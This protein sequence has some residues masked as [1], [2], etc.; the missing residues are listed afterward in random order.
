VKGARVERAQSVQGTTFYKACTDCP[1][2]D[3]CITSNGS[4][5]RFKYRQDTACV[6]SASYML[7]TTTMM[8][9]SDY[10]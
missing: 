2:S 5:D 1:E 8:F 3:S 9:L 4:V 7:I 6:Y 10:R